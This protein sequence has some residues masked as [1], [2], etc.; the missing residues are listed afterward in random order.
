MS[1]CLLYLLALVRDFLSLSEIVTACDN[2]WL[3]KVA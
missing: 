3:I 2:S 1:T